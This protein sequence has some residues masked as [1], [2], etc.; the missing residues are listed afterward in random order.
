[1]GRFFNLDSP[2]FVFMSKV[3]DLMILNVLCIICCLPF[4][5]AGASITALCYMTMKIVRGEDYYVLK[6]FFHSF[7]QNFK[8]ATVIHLIISVLVVILA[9]DLYFMKVMSA[10]NN[11]TVFQIMFYFFLVMGCFF[12]MVYMYI[13]PL[14]ARFYN[15]TKALFKNALLMAIRHF[16]YTLLMLVTTIAPVIVAVALPKLTSIVVLFY[17]LF[18]FSVVSYMCS[19]YLVKIFANYTPKEQEEEKAPNEGDD[20]SIPEIDTTVF[21]N[22]QPTNKPEE[23]ESEE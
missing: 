2:F 17:M 11:E 20:F 12:S 14:L 19:G 13:Y 7:K 6:G 4:F 23:D 9:F 15:P 1:M 10:S 16:P 8:Q 22:L 18:G 3:A 21:K 5:T